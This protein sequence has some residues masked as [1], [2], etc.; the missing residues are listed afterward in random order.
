LTRHRSEEAY[1]ISFCIYSLSKESKGPA[2]FLPT[3]NLISRQGDLGAQLDI[4]SSVIA[5]PVREA[6]LWQD[7]RSDSGAASGG[8]VVYEYLTIFQAGTIANN[9]FS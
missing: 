1:F 5:A 6:A 2:G 3:T 4:T 9:D 8:N 7:G